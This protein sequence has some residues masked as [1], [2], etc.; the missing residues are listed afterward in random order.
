MK[1]CPVSTRVN[2]T[3]NDDL[4]CALEVPILGTAQ[5]LF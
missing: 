4:E 3:E 2:R 5:M 1:K